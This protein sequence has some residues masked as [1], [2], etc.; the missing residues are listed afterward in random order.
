[1][2]DWRVPE[3]EEEIDECPKGPKREKADEVPLGI[4]R[5]KS[6]QF[7]PSVFAE[8]QIHEDEERE[9]EQLRKADEEPLEAPEVHQDYEI[10]DGEEYDRHLEGILSVNAIKE[11]I[12]QAKEEVE[13][14]LDVRVKPFRPERMDELT[15]FTKDAVEGYG[16][17]EGYFELKKRVRGLIVD[18]IR[19]AEEELDRKKEAYLRSSGK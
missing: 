11:L 8:R 9:H 16:E 19:F 4:R 6:P 12:L 7:D 2:G 18:D 13:A 17:T 5:P 14:E 10:R 3:D 1:M 15:V